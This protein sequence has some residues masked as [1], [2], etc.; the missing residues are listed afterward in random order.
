MSERF[1]TNIQYAPDGY[2]ESRKE[3]EHLNNM[4]EDEMNTENELF[5]KQQ[6]A[7]LQAM[8]D[9]K[10]ECQH[11]GKLRKYHSYGGAYCPYPNKTPYHDFDKTKTYKVKS[12]EQ[13]T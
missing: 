3:I 11:C 7:L 10:G 1:D 4:T 13:L 5:R 12:R 9:A 2:E 6:K 8:L